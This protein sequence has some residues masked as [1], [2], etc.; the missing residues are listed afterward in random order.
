MS[1]KETTK[2]EYRQSTQ[3]KT[4]DKNIKNDHSTSNIL[5]GCR[6]TEPCE[7]N[8]TINGLHSKV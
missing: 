5:V 1:T 8:I 4:K 6:S 7:K 3:A 2:K